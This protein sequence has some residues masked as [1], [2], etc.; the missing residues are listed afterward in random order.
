[1]DDYT[2]MVLSQMAQD[3]VSDGKIRLQ[4]PNSLVLAHC[5]QL[6]APSPQPLTQIILDRL[7]K[8]LRLP[9]PTSPRNAQNKT[10]RKTWRKRKERQV[11]WRQKTKPQSL[12]EEIEDG[13]ETEEE[14]EEGQEDMVET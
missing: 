1:M 8:V 11:S 12:R 14:E 2:E 3:A 7:S 9:L 10:L 5:P 13:C 4:V 6:F